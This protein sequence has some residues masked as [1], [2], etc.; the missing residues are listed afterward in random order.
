MWLHTDAKPLVFLRDSSASSETPFVPLISGDSFSCRL[1]GRRA[2]EQR[3]ASFFA[4]LNY[5]F[6]VA[7][8]FLLAQHGA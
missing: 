2:P 6:G 5:R 3:L 8:L 4:S 1:Y 7:K